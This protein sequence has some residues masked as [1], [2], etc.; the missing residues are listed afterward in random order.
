MSKY[1]RK[2]KY[3]KR[4]FE[5]YAMKSLEYCYDE[6]WKDCFAFTEE[7]PDLQSDVLNI[8]IEVT[9]S[10][11]SRERQINSLFN[12]FIQEEI[13]YEFLKNKVGLLGGNIKKM[14]QCTVLFYNH[15]M[16]KFHKSIE[17][18]VKIIVIKNQEKLPTYRQFSQNMLYIFTLEPLFN[19][20]DM[21]KVCAL[22]KKELSHL[23]LTFDLYFINCVNS[24]FVLNLENQKIE[25]ILITDDMLK[26]IKFESLQLSAQF[27]DL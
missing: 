22:L 12:R 1:K 21:Q 19:E 17:N 10:S 3:N 24:L 4:Y 16:Y 15:G 13:S 27:C 20:S 25:K 6:L 18:L 9:S 8:G 26:K 2:E 23:R 7:K 11:S 5:I 14:D